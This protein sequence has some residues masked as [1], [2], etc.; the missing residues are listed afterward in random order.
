MGYISSPQHFINFLKKIIKESEFNFK[1][2][3]TPESY[4]DFIYNKGLQ[5]EFCWAVKTS[6]ELLEN[7][8]LMKWL[9]KRQSLEDF[10]VPSKLENIL[11]AKF[12]AVVKPLR[13]IPG[14]YSFWTKKDTPIYVGFSID[15]RNR[16]MGSFSERFVNYKKTI[17]FKYIAA[18]SASDAALLK[19]YFICKL[20]PALNSTS[21][22]T[23]TLTINLKKEPI[24]SKPILCNIVKK[25]KMGK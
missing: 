20:K 5:D 6:P 23:D 4:I 12:I 15:L 13:K 16:I 19:I 24:F 3:L 7:E 11:T 17:Y 8:N 2:F 18:K 9:Q 25:N 14:V 21:K 10:I 22:Y 1:E